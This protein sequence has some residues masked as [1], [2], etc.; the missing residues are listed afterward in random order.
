M[1]RLLLATT[2]HETFDAFLVPYAAHFR[3]LGWQVDLVA[4]GA[5]TCPTCCAGVDHV[6]DA[7]WARHPFATGNL[8][9]VAEVRRIVRAGRHDLVH[10]HTPVAA[11]LARA[12]LRPSWRDRS[13]IRPRVVYTAHGFHFDEAARWRT[14][15][16]ELAERRAGP[17][18]DHLV[19]INEEDLA[20]AREHQVVA[21]GA[22][23]HMP[24]I[25]VD[26]THYRR[27]DALRSRA[28]AV[29]SELGLGP[30]TPLFTM[31][32]EFI[33]R[34][35]HVDVVDALARVRPEAHLALVGDG[36]EMD[37][38]R[39]RTRELGLADRV[40]LVGRRRDVRPWVLAAAATV[41]PSTR[42]G[43]PRC[44][45]EA[46][47]LGVPVVATDIRGTREL[48]GG[49][50][51]LLVPVSAPD[52]LA[53]A[54]TRVLA[55]PGG[56]RRRAEAARRHV[57]RYDLDALLARHERTYERLLG[58]AARQEVAS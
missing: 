18:T 41:L 21:G 1:P 9:E 52:R 3:S 42:E 19:V 54:M 32:A 46:M 27:T 16:Y 33:P 57:V 47:S 49:D 15:P 53:A 23:E 43:L 51:G 28:R 39:Q 55:D 56:A 45:M 31:V 22:L 10:V 11:L 26:L 24:G 50:R 17:W 25:G 20:W 34:K 44:V 2:V 38:V 4:S 8:A 29:R 48:V 30:T 36:P 35:R 12:A 37:A 40:H 7:T 5:P 14:L 13:G 6:H 58:A